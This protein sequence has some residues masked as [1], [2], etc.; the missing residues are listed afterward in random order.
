MLCARYEV[1][2]PT[3][4]LGFGALR[5]DLRD[6]AERVKTLYGSAQV[7]QHPPAHRAPADV[8]LH[9]ADTVRVQL[10]VEVIGH[11]AADVAT[12][13]VMALHWVQLRQSAHFL[14]QGYRLRVSEFRYLPLRPARGLQRFTLAQERVS[15]ELCQDR[16]DDPHSR[17]T[18]PRRRPLPSA[19]SG[20]AP[21]PGVSCSPP[22]TT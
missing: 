13:R 14:S 10:T 20:C 9:L 7:L 12:M 6:A 5:A 4:S 2:R 21:P 3:S 18:W 15:P 8:P 1:L 19:R 16:R 22:A 17:G 11:F